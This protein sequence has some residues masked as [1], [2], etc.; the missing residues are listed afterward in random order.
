MRNKANKT[1]EDLWY[2]VKDAISKGVTA[3]E[4]REE[5]T[6]CFVEAYRE[7]AEFAVK[8]FNKGK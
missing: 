3:E 5:A 6:Q 7:L 4:F 1:A 2:V 8:D